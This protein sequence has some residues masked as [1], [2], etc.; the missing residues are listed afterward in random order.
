MGYE[1]CAGGGE[2]C[3]DNDPWYLVTNIA[4]HL[5]L[6]GQLELAR[7]YFSNCLANSKP[8]TVSSED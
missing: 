7:F 8:P 6:A 3:Y 4:E 1:G 2:V 5:D